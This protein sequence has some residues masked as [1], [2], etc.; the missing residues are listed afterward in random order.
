MQVFKKSVS[1]AEAGD[2]VGINIKNIQVDAM[3]KGMVLVKGDSMEPTN[4]FEG[5]TYFLAKVRKAL[6]RR[7]IFS[8]LN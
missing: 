2:N 3:K 4:H 1:I 8:G 6:V 7:A 5:I